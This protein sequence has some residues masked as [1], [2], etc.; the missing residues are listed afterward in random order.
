MG[1]I[2]HIT[3]MTHMTHV[4]HI[5]PIGHITHIFHIAHITHVIHI[6]HMTTSYRGSV[7]SGSSYMLKQPVVITSHD[8]V[9]RLLTLLTLPIL[10]D[11]L[12]A[13]IPR[14]PRT[15]RDRPRWC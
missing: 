13:R 10:L 5:T 4:I 11:Y 8:T 6:T 9:P 7:P 3:H 12:T 14:D 1:H 2:T 15:R